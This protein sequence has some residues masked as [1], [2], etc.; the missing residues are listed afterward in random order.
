[1]RLTLPPDR[2]SVGMTKLCEKGRGGVGRVSTRSFCRKATTDTEFVLLVRHEINENLSLDSQCL[3]TEHKD[4]PGILA[5]SISLIYV[6]RKILKGI[7]SE[8]I[9]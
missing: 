6:S 8:A 3:H 5:Y 4:H 7:S 1:M 2:Y 9:D